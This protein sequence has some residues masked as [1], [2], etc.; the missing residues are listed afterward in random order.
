MD[1]GLFSGFGSQ[2][3]S[4][5]K[6]HLF[7]ETVR[8]ERI[9]L[10]NNI[11]GN[12]SSGGLFASPNLPAAPHG[13][14]G[15]STRDSTG[16]SEQTN[17]LEEPKFE[18]EDTEPYAIDLTTDNTLDNQPSSFQFFPQSYDESRK[19][20]LFSYLPSHLSVNN[21]PSKG[22]FFSGLA[23]SENSPVKD[24][25]PSN[26]LFVGFSKT[27]QNKSQSL[28]TYY[29]PIGT[30][31]II[32]QRQLLNAKKE[33]QVLFDQS[34]LQQKAIPLSFSIK[35]SS[36]VP[37]LT[38]NESTHERAT[39]V[40]QRLT[41]LEAKDKAEHER[42]QAVSLPLN[43]RKDA[44]KFK[45]ATIGTCPDMCPETER[46]LR[47]FRHRVSLFETHQNETHSG[48]GASFQMDHTRA[49]KD[50]S[51]S[52]ADQAEPLP[53]E[54]RP[55]DV[56]DRTMNYLLAAIADRP[57]KEG[58]ENLWK[59]WYEFLWTRTRA[60][61]KDITQQRLCSPTIVSIVEKITR[62]HIFCAAR[63]VDQSLDAFDPRINSENLTQCLQTLKEL[64]SDIQSSAGSNSIVKLCPCEA[65]F[66]AY[67]ILMKLNE[68]SV[69]D[70][71]QKFPEAIRKSPEVQFAISVHSAV[72]ERNH[73]RFFRLIRQADCLTGCLLHR[74]FGQVRSHALLALSSAFFGH[75]RHEVIYP[76]F[77]FVH[78]L[79]FESSE[80]AQDFCEHWGVLVSNEVVVFSRNSPA[81]EP[82]IAWKERRSPKLVEGKRKGRSLC[83]LFN[84]GPL[85]SAFEKP[86]PIHSSF[87]VE[88]NLVPVQVIQQSPF[89]PSSNKTN[90]SIVHADDAGSGNGKEEVID[91]SAE[92]GQEE[93]EGD[94]GYQFVDDYDEENESR[95]DVPQP[96]PVQVSRPTFQWHPP[97]SDTS[98]ITNPR[99]VPSSTVVIDVE[100]DYKESERNN[101]H[102]SS[103]LWTDGTVIAETVDRVARDLIDETVHQ[104]TRQICSEEVVQ[105]LSL[106]SSIVEEVA[107]EVLQSFLQSALSE[108]F[109]EIIGDI[110]IA[111]TADDLVVEEVHDVALGEVK[112]A[113]ARRSNS[114]RLQKRSFTVWRSICQGKSGQK[115]N[116]KRTLDR[117]LT[118]P[119][120]PAP[121]A[122]MGEM[123]MRRPLHHVFRE[124][125]EGLEPKRP[126]LSDANASKIDATF[127]SQPLN[128]IPSLQGIQIAVLTS[129]T[130][131]EFNRWVLVMLQNYPLLNPIPSIDQL[132]GSEGG[133]IN[134]SGTI[135]GL[136]LP[137]LCLFPPNFLRPKENSENATTKVIEFPPLRDWW[138]NLIEHGLNWFAKAVSN[139]IQN[140]SHTRIK[141][142]NTSTVPLH[143][144]IA[145]STLHE[146]V[147]S[148]I[149]ANFVKPLIELISQWNEFR[150]Q[151]P[152]PRSILEAYNKCLEPLSRCIRDTLAIS[153]LPESI[154]DGSPWEEA[155]MA[156]NLFLDSPQFS[157]CYVASVKQY[158]EN[159]KAWRREG[160]LLIPWGNLC[161]GLIQAKINDAVLADGLDDND[162]L[163]S[164]LPESIFDDLCPQ[165]PIIDT[166]KQYE[167]KSLP[168]LPPDYDPQIPRP[169]PY[170]S[171]LQRLNEVSERIDGVSQ[172][173]KSIV[174]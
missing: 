159:H 88:G 99:L 120:A 129:T 135:K 31:S 57:E 96:S 6:P 150:L 171:I 5:S 21:N 170:A 61:R 37:S 156:W 111:E 27:P 155:V 52:A 62:F 137:Q 71:V 35:K 117:L 15:L 109:H 48:F 131:L 69:L 94:D 49:V 11:S 139:H 34:R 113:Q 72:A 86:G 14:F 169:N 116:S 75:P 123:G 126:R 157:Q 56:L 40:Q 172:N 24:I 50:Y 140:N 160:P 73:V 12:S 93:N 54:L 43:P 33:A 124:E 55:P 143:F 112:S 29:K 7:S 78:Q 164:D 79:G 18:I 47:E 166:R 161:I 102:Q 142:E 149:E 83:D 100:N 16:K 65:E 95:E 26:N 168:V 30:G 42:R 133:I 68:C 3:P 74:Y 128:P 80:D 114:L 110:S 162:V 141:R 158:P 134:A 105:C 89:C 121:F 1:N 119:G 108:V 25:A 130:F 115:L 22:D 154:P 51:R 64:Y 145:S 67:M 45:H 167:S 97:F 9:G 44:S 125:I 147:N 132:S 41:I 66:R 163:E 146:I 58:G 53:W 70:E 8:N 38:S 13:L 127:N 152:D 28:A 174:E 32:S 153:P 82:E 81:R 138:R 46:Y 104:L 10:F 87:D 90:A 77:K 151:H 144:Y 85:D 106:G 59:P 39:T 148:H 98:D 107:E 19:S 165:F 118:L 23:K 60:I 136:N 84:G 103:F 101:V 4:F 91:L 36:S 122:W 76:L 17:S 2:G 20:S 92:E 173:A 63:L